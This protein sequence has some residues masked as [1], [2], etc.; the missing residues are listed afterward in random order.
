ML[1]P[2]T[3][4]IVAGVALSWTAVL[5]AVPDSTVDLADYAPF[6]L[7]GLVGAIFAN[8]TG[9]GGGVVFIPMF[10]QLG[11]ADSRAVAT[12]FGIQCFGMTAGALTWWLHYRRH[13]LDLHLWRPLLPAVAVTLPFS[14]AGI[15]LVYGGSLQT[16]AS[17]EKTFGVFSI[18]LGAAILLTVYLVPRGHEHSRLT[19]L[20]YTALSLIGLGGGIITAWLSVG[21]GEIMATY[22][23]LRRFDVTMSVAAAVMV[24]A[25]SV[26]SALPQHALLQP[27]VH[28]P[29]LLFA[30]P[31]AVIG[32]IL[33]RVLVTHLS[34]R[35]LKIFFGAWVLIMGLSSLA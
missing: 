11:F 32:G 12:S 23:I 25:L 13:K 21:V 9:A 6:A 33:A 10:D 14:V 24:S 29:V 8:S 7:L 5:L 20:D 17:L 31:A 26:W 28:W 34:A 1:R 16:P 3:G 4:A 30:G 22:L 2:R 35:K 18:V 19:G 15:W 27:E